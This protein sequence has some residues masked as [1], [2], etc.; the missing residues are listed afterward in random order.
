M[1]LKHQAWALFKSCS[2]PETDAS[3]VSLWSAP[4]QEGGA[5]LCAL[6]GSARRCCCCWA[7]GIFGTC[8]IYYWGPGMAAVA[9]SRQVLV[10]GER[11]LTCERCRWL[12]WRSVCLIIGPFALLCLHQVVFDE[13]LQR[14][15]DSYLRHAPRSLDLA[16]LPASPAV[17]NMQRTIHRTV[18]LTFLRMATHKESK[19]EEHN[20]RTSL[21]S[22]VV[23]SKPQHI[24]CLSVC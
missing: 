9:A 20:G 16:T 7:G 8:Q 23:T 18:F 19:V 5:L 12:C 13:S 1:Q 4:T 24:V 17:A 11:L 2:Y 3:T 10:S 6:Q 21:S 14:C 15:L 22:C